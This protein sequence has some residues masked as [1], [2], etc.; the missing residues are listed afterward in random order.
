MQDDD[1]LGYFMLEHSDHFW[2]QCFD[3]GLS[4]RQALDLLIKQ[5]NSTVIVTHFMASKSRQ[6]G[7]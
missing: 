5:I 4:P 6:R 7:P 1:D 2:E 3:E